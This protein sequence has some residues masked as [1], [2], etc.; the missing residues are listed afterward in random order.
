M[1]L[2]PG[3]ENRPTAGPSQGFEPESVKLYR[4]L[5][6]A[7][8]GLVVRCED[9]VDGTRRTV[10]LA[11]VRPVSG[12]WLRACLRNEPP[13]SRSLAAPVPTPACV[14]QNRAVKATEG[15]QVELIVDSFCN[16]DFGVWNIS[17]DSTLLGVTDTK[18]FC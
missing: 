17:P 6:P 16:K 3:E 5:E 4:V 7:T 12:G 9:V 1:T 11:Q 13:A 18:P 10:E 15:T 8:R 2:T 14:A